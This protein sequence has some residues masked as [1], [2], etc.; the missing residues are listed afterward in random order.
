MASHL[1]NVLRAHRKRLSL[2]QEDVAFLLGVQSGAKVCRYERYCRQP[3]FETALAY[4]AIFQRRAAQLFAGIY[5]RIHRGVV[6]RARLLARKAAGKSAP[7]APTR[8]LQ[9]LLEI[10]SSKIIS[11]SDNE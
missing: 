1:P 4:E 10:A 5:Q 7:G 9:V 11:S 2:S 6:A 8:R 3:G